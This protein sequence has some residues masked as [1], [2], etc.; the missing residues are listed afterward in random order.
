M[1]SIFI[2]TL[3][4]SI[5]TS[6]FAQDYR[7]HEELGI[8]Q[9]I[10]VPKDKKVDKDN[11]LLT[12][13]FNRWSYQH[14]REIYPTSGIPKSEKINLI[15][16]K[17]DSNVDNLVKVQKDSNEVVSLPTYIQETYTDALVV[18]KGN[19]IVY[20]NYQNGMT[21]HQPHQM[22]SCTKS[23]AGL[24][25]LMAEE[26][27]KLDE[28]ELVTH[29]IPELNNTSAFNQ[30]KVKHI[31]DMTNSM[32]FDETYADPQSDIVHYG[33]VIGLMPEQENVSY[34][35]DIYEYLETLKIDSSLKHGEVFN[36]Q[37]PKTDVINWL[38]NRATKEDFQ[39]G[40]YRIWNTI[41]AEDETYVILDKNGAL[42]AGGGLNASPSDLARFS[43][44]MLNE[45][46]VKEK[47]VVPS[48]VI[49]KLQKGAN[50]EAFKN[51]S[52]SALDNGEWS[53][54]AQWWVRHTKGKEAIMAI[55][56][57]GQWIY[58][59]VG[60]DIA[61]VKQSSQP[62]SADVAMEAYNVRA[63]DALIDYFSNTQNNSR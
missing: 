30:A 54:R 46:K 27:G 20:E 18:V 14:M 60:R 32:S 61:I 40:L 36:Y 9:G 62:N 63:F 7:T 33:T 41:G 49:K 37:T 11:A 56:I 3:V 29:Y 44:M 17:I 12:F 55:G 57:H 13:P 58:I 25:A 39:K 52:E 43:M 42:F 35:N 59:D 26:E 51:G 16:R 19:E 6:L 21:S 23:F 2:T 53:Y 47:Q 10:P 15:N 50:T 4:L 28:E 5:T 22:M 1:K 38:T 24:L 31:L 48:S 8:M 34:A 45:G